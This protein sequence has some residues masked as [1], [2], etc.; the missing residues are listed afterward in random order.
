[1]T[2]LELLSVAQKVSRTTNDLLNQC[3]FW[4]QQYV[5]LSP[6]QRTAI[7]LWILHTWVLDFDS[8]PYLH[9]TA[10]ESGCGKSRLLEVL[11]PLV[12]R[13]WKTDTI[14]K[15]VLVRRVDAERPTLLL[16]E[17]DAV[18][19]LKTEYS[20]ELRGVLNAGFRSNGKYSCCEKG[21]DGSISF[22]DFSCFCA[23]ALCGIDYLPHTIESRSVLIEMRRKKAEETVERFRW[24][25]VKERA[26]P[27]H[28]SLQKWAVQ[29]APVLADAKP[30]PIDGISDRQQDVTEPLLAIADLAAGEWPDRARRALLAL[31]TRRTA[32]GSVRSQA[33]ALLSDIRRVFEARATDRIGSVELVRELCSM[34][35]CAWAEARLDVFQ[36]ARR[37]ARFG[38]KPSKIRIGG[39]T[40]NGYYRAEFLEAWERYCPQGEENTRTSGTAEVHE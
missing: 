9:I 24:R 20:E 28:K 18:F 34:E 25:E 39:S 10:P 4:I 2:E 32:Q 33:I 16:D 11:E 35:A 17:L 38:I 26:T 13:P 30:D 36:L 7:A 19:S 5:V 8:T 3:D 6:E 40:P 27:I 31:L 14:T 12:C 22:R 29:A 21:P 1:M 15:A 37:L 23:K